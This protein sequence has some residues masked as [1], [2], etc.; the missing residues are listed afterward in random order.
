M[1][2]EKVVIEVGLE[3]VRLAQKIPADPLGCIAEYHCK[4]EV[5]EFE[6]QIQNSYRPVNWFRL[7]TC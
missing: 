3:A 6:E 4:V 7:R 5:A 2:G 1:D